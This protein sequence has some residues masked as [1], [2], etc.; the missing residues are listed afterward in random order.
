M[1][2]LVSL[3]SEIKKGEYVRPLQRLFPLEVRSE[4][5]FN[6]KSNLIKPEKLAEPEIQKRL[7]TKSGRVKKKEMFWICKFECYFVIN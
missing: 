2:I 6:K 3:E 5:D 7:R 4:I 1:G